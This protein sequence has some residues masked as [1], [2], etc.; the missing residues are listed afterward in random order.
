MVPFDMH[1]SVK[2]NF[3]GSQNNDVATL[4]I[5]RLCDFAACL[6]ACLFCMQETSHAGGISQP[7]ISTYYSSG[8]FT[9][10]APDSKEIRGHFEVAL[11]PRLYN[12]FIGG[13]ITCRPFADR[14]TRHIRGLEE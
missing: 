1:L 2:Q 12:I 8:Y 13:P 7:A 5:G 11:L 10:D 9:H 3:E 6:L 14:Q 4:M